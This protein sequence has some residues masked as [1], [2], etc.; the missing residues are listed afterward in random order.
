VKFEKFKKSRGW[1]NNAYGY[2][3]ITINTLVN[4]KKQFQI[5]FNV[6]AKILLN[7]TE[8]VELL[9]D[10]KS[11][12]LG[13]KPTNSKEEYKVTYYASRAI[14]SGMAFLKEYRIEPQ[15]KIPI[16]WNKKLE[17]LIAKVKTPPLKAGGRR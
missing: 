8:R 16:K 9:F 15:Q 12:S 14:V 4:T 11:K 1:N 3:T 6:K 17:M 2:P 10:K 5:T 13:I 7:K